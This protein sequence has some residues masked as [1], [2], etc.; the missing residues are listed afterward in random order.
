MRA[1]RGFTLVELMV[2]MILGLL[3]VGGSLALFAGQRTTASMANQMSEVQSEARIALDALARDLRAAGDFGCWPVSNPTINKLNTSSAFDA[4]AGGLIGYNNGST[5]PGTGSYGA[6][7]VKSYSPSSSSSVVV[8]LGVSGSL[9]NIATSHGMSLQTDDLVIKRPTVDFQA[10]DVAVITDCVNWTKFQITSVSTD[11]S[12][13][14]QT[15][16]HAAGT[17]VSGL[18]GGNSD[19]SLGELFGVG[20]TVGRLDAIWWYVAAGPTGQNALYRMSARDGAPLL[21]SNRIERFHVTYDVAST[22]SGTVTSKDLEASAVTDWSLVRSAR[23]QVLARSEKLS[24]A[25]EQTVTTFAG[26][27]VPTDNHVYFP[28]EMVVSLRNQ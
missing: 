8:F 15:L 11:S 25:G 19:D 22:S 18:G 27:S 3:V 9:S 4:A 24:R 13:S 14:T 28:V 26:E 23:I 17:T 6:S 5:F 21:V 16:A 2:A 12:A 1:Q 7:T 10:N 20:A